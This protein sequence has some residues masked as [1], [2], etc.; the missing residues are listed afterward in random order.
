VSLSSLKKN[1]A[2]SGNA[3][4]SILSKSYESK[5]VEVEEDKKQTTSNDSQVFYID[6][7]GNFSQGFM[8]F[9]QDVE[10]ED[11]GEVV[12]VSEEEP[13]PSVQKPKKKKKVKNNQL[14]QQYRNDPHNLA[15]FETYWEMFRKKCFKETSSPKKR[16]KLLE[17]LRMYKLSEK[18]GCPVIYRKL[19]TLVRLTKTSIKDKKKCSGSG[20]R[21][22]LKAFNRCVKEKAEALKL[23]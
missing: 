2:T 1:T 7:E 20:I 10:E 12:V 14:Q 13:S 22:K 9:S 18:N 3:V 21:K 23:N 15:I 4:F 6:K 19:C 16:K 5:E 17:L 8:S 11:F